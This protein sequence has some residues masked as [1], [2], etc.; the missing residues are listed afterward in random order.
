MCSNVIFVRFV[1]AYPYNCLVN[2]KGEAWRNKSLCILRMQRVH[3]TW[4]GS[5]ASTRCPHGHRVVLRLIIEIARAAA[6]DCQT[7]RQDSE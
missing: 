7:D 4:C 6:D 3:S 5:G 2:P 1:F